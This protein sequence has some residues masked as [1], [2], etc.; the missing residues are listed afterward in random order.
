MAAQT[1]VADM[2]AGDDWLHGAEEEAEDPLVRD[3]PAGVLRVWDIHGGIAS[4]LLDGLCRG[5]IGAVKMAMKA[6]ANKGGHG[7]PLPQH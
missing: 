3:P 6:G 7:E 5:R 4:A 2:L 1:S